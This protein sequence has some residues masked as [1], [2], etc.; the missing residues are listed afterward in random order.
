M[1]GGHGTDSPIFFPKDFVAIYSSNYTLGQIS[2]WALVTGSGL[3]LLSR[4]MT[5]L[6]WNKLYRN[7]VV[8]IILAHVCHTVGTLSQQ[9]HP[10]VISLGPECVQERHTEAL[11]ELSLWFLDLPSK[12]YCLRKPENFYP[13][14][15]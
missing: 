10:A 14:S 9:T 11:E 5:A 7:Q 13:L 8:N 1:A 15:R 6:H 2:H 4:M 12:S 3:V